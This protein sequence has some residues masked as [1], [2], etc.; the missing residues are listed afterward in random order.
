M[1]R[2]TCQF[3]QSIPFFFLTFSS[4]S[5]FILNLRRGR[6]V[7]KQHLVQPGENC[8]GGQSGAA[9]TCPH[10]NHQDVALNPAAARNVKM[11]IG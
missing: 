9:V 2:S 5:K 8:I 7:Q 6:Y 1:P 4:R 3:K 10:G 11:D